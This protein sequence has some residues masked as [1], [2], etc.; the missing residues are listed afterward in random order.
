MRTS[1][2]RATGL[3]GGLFFMVSMA[4][5]RFSTAT[6]LQGLLVA[7][8]LGLTELAIVLV[9]HSYGGG[10]RRR[11]QIYAP[12]AREQVR[13]QELLTASEE[14]LSYLKQELQKLEDQAEDFR[15]RV[16]D[17]EGSA[18]RVET[19]VKSAQAA[20]KDGYLRG[21]RENEAAL[22]EGERRH[23]PDKDNRRDNDE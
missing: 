1:T 3:W 10:L 20:V 19:L 8:A 5:L 12:A 9:L 16:F 2:I 23:I 15:A 11:Y 22:L 7:I 6:D 13:K 14:E 18:R 17:R 21:I 4:I